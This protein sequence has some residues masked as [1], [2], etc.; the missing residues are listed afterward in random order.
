[1]EA[2]D[3][4]IELFTFIATIFTG[5]EREGTHGCAACGDGR[6]LLFC[7]RNHIAPW[8]STWVVGIKLRGRRPLFACACA[9]QLSMF[10]GMCAALHPCSSQKLRCPGTFG[11]DIHFARQSLALKGHSIFRVGTCPNAKHRVALECESLPCKM[12]VCSKVPRTR[13]AVMK[14]NVELSQQGPLV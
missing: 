4:E 13:S 6:A 8:H 12:Y 7:T 5:K 3:W 11:T 9:L 1:M 2:I 14:T 10:S